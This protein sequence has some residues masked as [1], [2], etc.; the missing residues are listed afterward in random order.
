LL[1]GKHEK[2]ETP[3]LK[4]DYL[5]VGVLVLLSICSLWWIIAGM[6][7]GGKIFLFSWAK[8]EQPQFSV[9]SIIASLVV[10]AAAGLVLYFWFKKKNIH[11]IDNTTFNNPILQKLSQAQTKFFPYSLSGF[12]DIYLY[13]PIGLFCYKLS[14]LVVSV[15]INVLTITLD[16][17]SRLT[18]VGAHFL[19][20]LDKFFVD[21]FVNLLGKLSLYI[22]KISGTYFQSFRWQ[23]QIGWAV[24]LFFVII[25]SILLL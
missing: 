17:F 5:P 24:T 8:L 4:W 20:T 10:N 7:F 15:E 1:W 14:R 11:L 25:L 22:G 19:S 23:I 13:Q 12:L 18:V 9:W 21:G 16:K 6:P 2:E 3:L